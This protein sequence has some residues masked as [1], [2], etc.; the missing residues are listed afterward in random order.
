MTTPIKAIEN[1]LEYYGLNRADLVPIIGSRARVSE[2]MN[3]KRPLTLAMIRR[4]HNELS[5]D[6]NILIQQY[7]VNQ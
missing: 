2:I 1:A 7:K 4:L 5:I 6:A 3:K